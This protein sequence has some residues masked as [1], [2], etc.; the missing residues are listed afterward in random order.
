MW[1]KLWPFVFAIL[2]LFWPAKDVDALSISVDCGGMQVGTITVSVIG[3]A[4]TGGFTSN[5]PMFPTLQA[6]AVKCGE[7]HFNW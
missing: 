3:P 7:D 2:S 4:V 6:A 1:R 5:A